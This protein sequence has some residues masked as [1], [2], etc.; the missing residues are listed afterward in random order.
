[1]E[2]S[3]HL[4]CLFSAQVEQR[5]DSYIVEIPEQEF[6]LGDIEEGSTYRVAVL[7]TSTEPPEKTER[8]PE[9][10]RGHSEPPVEKG[11]TREVEIEDVGQ[12]GDGIARVERGYVVIVSDADRGD[13]VVIEIRDVQEN[14]AFAEVVDRLKSQ[15]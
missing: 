15:E 13:R 12:E 6:R 9:R 7:S 11:E 4:R 8:N 2:I 3:D 5:D 1:M 10:E 14:V